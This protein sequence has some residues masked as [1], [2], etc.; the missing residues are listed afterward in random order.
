M[1]L[2]A[3][4]EALDFGGPH[5]GMVFIRETQVRYTNVNWRLGYRLCGFY[6]AA[7]TDLLERDRSHWGINIIENITE[8]LKA[9]II[10]WVF[11]IS[12]F[13]HRTMKT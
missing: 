13:Q 10:H 1:P 2:H 6:G 7:Q 3:L 12:I 5:V 11:K 9:S 8:E 4:P